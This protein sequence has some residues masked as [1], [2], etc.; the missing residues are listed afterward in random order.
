MP[1]Y[2]V[3]AR[4]LF[5]P[6]HHGHSVRRCDHGFLP[7]HGVGPGGRRL[8]LRPL[9]QLCL[10]VHRIDDGG[11]GG[12][13]QSRRC[14]RARPGR[15]SSRSPDDRGA[16]SAA[17]SA[18]RPRRS[19]SDAPDPVVDGAL[20]HGQRHRPLV[21]D[22]HVEPA[23]VEALAEARPWRGRAARG[24]SARRSC[25]RAPGPATTGSDRPRRRRR[26]RPGRCARPCSR[27]P[28]AGSSRERA[29]RCRRPAAR[30]ETPAPAGGRSGCADR[31]RGRG[32]SRAFRRTAPSLRRRRCSRWRGETSAARPA[33]S[34]ARSAGGAPE[35]PRA[36][37]ASP[38]PRSVA[39]SRRWRW[40]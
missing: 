21:E 24:S 10:A 13:W 39:G 33:P 38:C 4:E 6:S 37:P 16:S 22:D 20:E 12:G 35:R 36:P 26:A 31:G 23:Q 32:R 34:P 2:A 30:R 15:R 17:G 1:L 5:R 28:A 8:D 27:S 3:L 18:A 29:F 9:R 25:S 7:W 11:L 40:H 14:S 19:P